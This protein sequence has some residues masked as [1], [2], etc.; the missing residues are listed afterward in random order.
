[1]VTG[2]M[3]PV[4]IMNLASPKPMLATDGIYGVFVPRE[5][6]QA[7]HKALWAQGLGVQADDIIDASALWEAGK[8]DDPEFIEQVW[9]EI[10]ENF[11]VSI[12]NTTYTLWEDGDLFLIPEGWDV[13]AWDWAYEEEEVCCD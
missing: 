8:L 1:M 12:D 4:G 10:L 7:Y 9:V 3:H 11:Q 6:C 2:V 5:F 13:V